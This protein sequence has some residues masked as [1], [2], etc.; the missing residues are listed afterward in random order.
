[1]V[2][3]LWI[4]TKSLSKIL[5]INRVF[6]MITGNAFLKFLTFYIFTV[7]RTWT[8]IRIANTDPEGHWIRIW[9]RT[10]KQVGQPHLQ[11]SD[12]VL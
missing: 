6:Q 8:R 5:K 2:K 9:I 7:L 1:M 3:H 4:R 10:T 11:L 12:R